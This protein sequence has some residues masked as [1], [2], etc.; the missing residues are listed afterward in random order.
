M[1][2]DDG[3]LMFIIVS[4]RRQKQKNDGTH[5]TLYKF[6]ETRLFKGEN[7]Q[8]VKQGIREHTT[9]AYIGQ[10]NIGSI[11]HVLFTRVPR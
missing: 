10:I 4:I 11:F 8:Y 5:A 2:I 3:N 9:T 6:I 7:N 1:S